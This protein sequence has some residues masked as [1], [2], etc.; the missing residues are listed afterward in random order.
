MGAEFVIRFVDTTDV[1]LRLAMLVVWVVHA[2]FWMVDPSEVV[3]LG[4]MSVFYLAMRCGSI[5]FFLVERLAGRFAFERD[6]YPV[7]L[8]LFE[9][10]PFTGPLAAAF[11]S[12]FYTCIAA[13]A[14]LALVAHV[15]WLNKESLDNSST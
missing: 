15:F 8:Q 2:V 9:R 5:A 7:L 11:V 14:G 13:A 4:A 3:S 6:D 10:R 12:L 1:V